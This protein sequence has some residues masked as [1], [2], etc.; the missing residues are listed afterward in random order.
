M[1]GR[2]GRREGREGGKEVGPQRNET[3]DVDT[4]REAREVG[5]PEK[6]GMEAA[7][8]EGTRDET[9][10]KKRGRDGLG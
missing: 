4:R 5:N 9:G 10:S 1:G 7:E 8:G 3:G 6:D 2:D